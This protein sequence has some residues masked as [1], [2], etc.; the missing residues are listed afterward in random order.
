MK[1]TEGTRKGGFFRRFLPADREEAR[2]QFR[3]LLEKV[4]SLLQQNGRLSKSN[5]R[6]VRMLS[7][8]DRKLSEIRDAA[9]LGLQSAVRRL[10]TD[11]KAVLRRLFLDPNGLEQPYGLTAHRFRMAS[12]NE[13]DGIL[14]ALF[15]KVGISNR[16]FV[17]IGS[18][19]NGGNSGF[20]ARECGWSGLMIDASA[21][22]ILKIQ[23]RYNPRRV[24]AVSSWVTR[25]NINQL[26]TENGFGGEVDLLSLDIDSVDYWVWE[27]L[28]V[29]SPRVAVIE[30]NSAFGPDLAVTV[31]YEAMFDRHRKKARYYY[32]A[33]LAAFDH[34]AQKKGYRLIAAEPRGVNA[35]F[36]RNDVMPS[37]PACD[38]Q[39][40]F[41]M[42]EK[43]GGRVD[44]NVI[45]HY[46]FL[47][48]PNLPLVDVRKGCEVK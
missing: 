17:E 13:E 21:E 37:I 29:C 1:S 47:K 24:K 45:D 33:S 44:S 31:P 35:F 3:K 14:L 5:A 12:Q 11:M 32:G 46:A 27:A 25:E 23:S 40:A 39:T 30:Y 41:Q 15:K 2:D 16:R 26:L 10:E 6:L 19:T 42:I 38:V 34:L 36:L 9:D 48:D 8:K 28:T 20:L 18:G 43:H 4:D 7:E 22:R